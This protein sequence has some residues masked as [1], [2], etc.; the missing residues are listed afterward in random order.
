M[1]PLQFIAAL[2]VAL[3]W[4]NPVV[5]G[6]SP[7]MVQSLVTLACSAG[8]LMLWSVGWAQAGRGLR[9][10]DA[11][12]PDAWVA[13]IAAGWL[14]AGLL[15]GLMGLVQYAGLAELFQPWISRTAAGEAFANLRQRNQ[16][17]TLLN[18]GL[19]A[20]LWFAARSPVRP[21]WRVQVWC[22]WVCMLLSMANAA[23]SSRTGALELVFILAAG[24]VWGHWRQSLPRRI[25]IVSVLT[26]VAAEFLLPWLSGL[27]AMSGMLGRLR[28]GEV[29]CTSRLTLWS[30]VLHLIA[31]KP[32]TGW[33]WGELD[34][35]HYVT[36]YA[37]ARF[38]DL[39]DNAHN[40]PLHLAVELG[41]PVAAVVCGGLTLWVLRA[42]PW[43][44]RNPAR[45]LAWLVLGVIGLHSLLEYPLWYGPFQMAAVLA[46]L[47][48]MGGRNPNAAQGFM[49]TGEAFARRAAAAG[50][51]LLL[52]LCGAV[53]WDYRQISQIYL[54]P[55]ERD[56]GF[57]TDTLQKIQ[58]SRLF[59]EQVRFAE[60]GITPLTRENAQW[61]F[62]TASALLH[63]SPEPR[64]IE[65][66][67]ESATLLG[68]DGDAREHLAHY[69]AA[70]P[71]Q[72]AKWSQRNAAQPAGV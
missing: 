70:Y 13:A 46:T 31:Q 38:C 26:Y 24:A 49:R 66:V 54:P 6:P 37:G 44:E 15:S 8:L 58:G 32:W 21:G 52:L 64:V 27:P 28:G 71:E 9:T 68:R 35:A 53:A 61:T 20:L 69:K 3:P 56:E 12:S 11:A 14:A 42:R 39:L 60:L 63:Y 57:R 2:L 1:T 25:L 41:V 34:Y 55:T 4:L 36:P 17:A 67:I 33:G 19:A 47:V 65:R 22:L 29:M 45:Q 43:S 40:L 50:A 62:D 10:P 5:W 51:V 72:A 59:R 23:S 7:A 18:M 30:N 16:F 48:L